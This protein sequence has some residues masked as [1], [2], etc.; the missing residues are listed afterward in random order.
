MKESGST[1]TA[2]R[3]LLF[4]ATGLGTPPE[5]VHDTPRCATAAAA[6]VVLGELVRIVRITHSLVLL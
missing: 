6:I 5:K 4:A 2:D 3:F 1:T